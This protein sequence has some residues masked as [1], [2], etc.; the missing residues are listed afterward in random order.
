M[1]NDVNYE[2]DKIYIK[3]ID[4]IQKNWCDSI[5]TILTFNY[6]IYNILGYI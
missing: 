4:F 1:L 6:L 5:K 2:K 3:T